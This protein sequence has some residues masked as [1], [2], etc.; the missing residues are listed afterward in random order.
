MPETSGHQAKSGL[1]F[2]CAHGGD[3]DFAP[4]AVSPFNSRFTANPDGYHDAKKVNGNG[5][6]IKND[7][8][9]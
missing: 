6:N 3:S 9:K 4:F 2:L 8:L 7:L 5:G 1:E